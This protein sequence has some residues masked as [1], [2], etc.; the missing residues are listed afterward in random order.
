M[1]IYLFSEKG[2]IIS[3]IHGLTNN[4][5]YFENTTIPEISKKNKIISYLVEKYFS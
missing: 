3:N 1:E 2:Q 4:S 5:A